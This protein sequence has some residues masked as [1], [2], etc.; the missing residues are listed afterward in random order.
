MHIFNEPADSAHG[1]AGIY[2][3]NMVCKRTGAGNDVAAHGEDN[4]FHA[5]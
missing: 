5:E 4:D 2:D 1:I 3:G